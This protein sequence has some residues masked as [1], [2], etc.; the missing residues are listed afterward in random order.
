[1]PAPL[2]YQSLA[3]N[4]DP[5]LVVVNCQRHLQPACLDYQL[6][7]CFLQ[8][9]A[10]CIVPFVLTHLSTSVF[11]NA[12]VCRFLRTLL[13]PWSTFGLDECSIYWNQ[14]IVMNDYQKKTSSENIRCRQDVRSTR[15]LQFW[16]MPSRRVRTDDALETL[17]M[18]VVHNLFQGQTK[19]H[20]CDPE[21]N[22]EDM[23][24]GCW[25]EVN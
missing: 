14:G 10:R 25:H 23:K 18:F 19:P 9:L 17:A 3:T 21:V 5:R 12:S 13:S 16:D 24:V 4:F 8:M 15:R 6:H 20:I 11:F 1:M 2:L 22:R 7:Q